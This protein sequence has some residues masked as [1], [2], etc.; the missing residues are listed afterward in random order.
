[1]FGG[2]LA[3]YCPW[4]KGTE[5][6][7][8][9]NFVPET[10]N[11][12][13]Y[14]DEAQVPQMANVLHMVLDICNKQPTTWLENAGHLIQRRCTI[15]RFIQIVNDPVRNH[16]IKR[17]ISERQLACIA[18]LDLNAIRYS[19][20]AGVGKGRFWSIAGLVLC[21]PKIDPYGMPNR[22]ATCSGSE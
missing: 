21:Q 2:S 15:C 13:S 3:D 7:Q 9:P 12:M 20:G 11:N 22:D 10:G 18:G 4:L 6:N 1:M 19:F 17:A 16:H 14:V 5:S 8:S